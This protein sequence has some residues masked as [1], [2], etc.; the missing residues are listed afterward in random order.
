MSSVA[1]K[2]LQAAAGSNGNVVT[3]EFIES[4]H[5]DSF[6]V[7]LSSAPLAGDLLIAHSGGLFYGA[8]LT[9]YG[10]YPF[11]QAVGYTSSAWHT[12]SPSYYEGSTIGYRIAT[13]SES[14]T[15]SVGSADAALSVYRF[16]SP[17]T[18]V[19]VAFTTTKQQNG[20]KTITTSS[21]D[22]PHIVA[23]TIGS[24]TDPNLAM[25]NS[26]YSSHAGY[27]DAAS[28]LR[29]P[30]SSLTTAVITASSVSFNEACCYA[31]LVPNFD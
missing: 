16:S 14:R 28:S 30:D 9:L 19:T 6:N 8:S 5:A 22:K 21:Y 3:G 26:D 29:N 23:C 20:S 27:C 15:L 11:T 24:R 7:S 1:N 13:G 12:G 17:V 2:M 18:S 25:T 31:V 10:S 4:S